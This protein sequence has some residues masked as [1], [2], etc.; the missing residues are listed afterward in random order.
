MEGA[1]RYLFIRFFLLISIAII[2]SHSYGQFDTL[3]FV[4]CSGNVQIIDSQYCLILKLS[5]TGSNSIEVHQSRYYDT[6]FKNSDWLSER[7]YFSK[8]VRG[9]IMSVEDNGFRHR[10]LDGDMDKLQKIDSANPLV[11]SI[12][13]DNYIPFEIGEYLVHPE[14][15][16]FF[17][18]TR[19][20]ATPGEVPFK[21]Q[22]LP[23]KS[24][25]N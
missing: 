9:F 11:D 16:Y 7:I 6:K 18:S 14:I 20:T 1:Y 13:L 5:V 21:I 17:G 24:L 19:Y 3:N 12:I 25:F 15:D 8:I 2:N 23:P 22:F 4:N 10:I